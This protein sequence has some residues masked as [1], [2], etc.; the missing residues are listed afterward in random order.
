MISEKEF[1]TL[2]TSVQM[3]IYQ[4]LENAW[5]N[6]RLEE[7]LRT[8]GMEQLVPRKISLTWNDS[9]PNGNIIVIGDL[10]IKSREIIASITSQG[11][12]KKRIEL[13]L[14]YENLKRFNFGRLQYNS[15]Y[16]LILVGSIPHST[17][18]KGDF[19]SIINRMEQDEGFT[20]VVRLVS[21]EQ[22]KITKSNLKEAIKKEI[23]EGY[24]LAG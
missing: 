5:R 15:A 14:G 22:L 17:R 2:V 23:D 13:Q 10:S 9:L 7:Y 18:G 4:A 1:N 21:N 3:S 19:S 20:K 11:I 16:R 8:I 6:E 24:L 12:S